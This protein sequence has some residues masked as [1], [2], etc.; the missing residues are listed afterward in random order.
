MR[1]LR[2][3]T[4][5]L[6]A[7]SLAAAMLAGGV[8]V[9]LA[10]AAPAAALDDGLAR[11]PPMGFN[12]WNAFGCNVD[13]QLIEQTADLFVSSGL[14]DAGYEYVNIDDCWMTHERDPETGRLVPDPGKFPDGIAAVADYVHA[15]GLRLGI[16][17]SA[18]STTCAGY[19][20]SLGHETVDAQT[21]ADWGVDYLKYDNCGSH[22][23]YPD[24]QQGYIARYSAMRDA[25]EATGRD[26]VYSLCEWGNLQPWTWGADVGHLWRTTGDI[27]DNWSSLKSII[28]QNAPLA[29]YA[30]P[31]GWN[32]P[33]MLEVGNGGMTDTEYR[34]HFGL[35]AMMAAPLIIGTDLREADDATMRILGNRD[36]IAV[37]QDPLGVQADVVSDADG[38][39]VFAKPLA[40][41]DEAVALYN[42]SDRA[43]T[44]RTTAQ[45]VGLSGRSFLARDLWSGDE[46]ESAGTIVAHVPA[47]GTAMYRVSSLKGHGRYA[48]MTALSAD[49]DPADGVAEPGSPTTVRA[50][51]ED[52]GRH[53]L[54][55]ATLGVTAPD[56]WTVAPPGPRTAGKVSSGDTFDATWSVTP[57]ADTAP[58]DYD[59]AVT[60]AYRW[61]DEP[62][63]RE[64][65]RTTLT[66]TVPT[67]PPS[68]TT[69]L[70]DVAW[71]SETN[72][73]GPPE[74]DRS[75]GEQG[76][77][78]GGPITIG[79]VVYDKGIGA[80]AD[81]EIRWF[82]GGGC[83]RLTTDVGIDDE[84]TTN[85]SVTFRILAD[86][87]VAADSG[88]VTVDDPAAHLAADLTGA[89]WLTLVEDSGGDNNSDHGD[90]A[91]PLLTCD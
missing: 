46:R 15:R 64:T 18:G 11:T 22:G 20:G 60:A 29:S 71:V 35:W 53:S 56:G 28:R 44:I 26:I 66:V 68:G 32:D 21:F 33:D 25:L 67:L 6:G 91:G 3:L 12:D 40:D 62:D 43:Q 39:M 31:G 78:D 70:S 83:T 84:K 58:G 9:D 77:H 65:L 10:T 37:D 54:H 90:W 59:L 48:P 57:P 13:A 23:Q 42:E 76:A 55:D 61:G 19:P 87:D 73:W 16:Y 5:I 34:T 80:H 69:P 81:S 14:K 82:L 47:H 45:D 36:V 72:G 8:T 52:A 17:E 86:D 24:T 4:S 2:V 49:T 7:G 1:V 50:R 85:G 79:G 30:G 63:Q 74:I 51:L 89:R 75:N 38:A 27:Q 41:G 88:V